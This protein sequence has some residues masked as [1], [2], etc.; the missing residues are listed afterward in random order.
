M[1]GGM[2]L[3]SGASDVADAHIAALAVRLQDSI[4]TAD[5]DDFRLLT[6]HLGRRLC[7]AGRARSYWGYETPGCHRAPPCGAGP[8]GGRRALLA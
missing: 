6:S 3:R 1:V 2:L 4:V 5:A 8:L 7:A